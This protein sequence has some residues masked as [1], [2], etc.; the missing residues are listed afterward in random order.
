MKT[1]I[2]SII[3]ICIVLMFG[4]IIYGQLKLKKDFYEHWHYFP[5][6]FHVEL[7]KRKLSDDIPYH[8]TKSKPRWQQSSSGGYIYWSQCSIR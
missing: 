5:N 4:F 7:T 3:A 6:Q 1:L 8:L 2:K